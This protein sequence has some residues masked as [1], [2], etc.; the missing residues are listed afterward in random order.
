MSS[1]FDP[2]QCMTHQRRLPCRAETSPRQDTKKRRSEDPKLRV[3]SAATRVARQAPTESQ[4]QA[5]CSSRAVC[6]CDSPGACVPASA[7]GGGRRG[8][9][10]GWRTGASRDRI[11][12]QDMPGGGPSGSVIPYS[13]RI[14]GSSDLNGTVGPC[15]ATRNHSDGVLKPLLLTPSVFGFLF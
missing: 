3:A 12:G 1:R 2:R 4:M 5:A 11:C 7:G 8:H 15:S 10:S 9:L 6:I 13:L 14:V